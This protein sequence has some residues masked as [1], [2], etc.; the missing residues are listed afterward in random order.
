MEKLALFVSDD[1]FSKYAYEK[2][3]RK[4][5]V[6]PFSIKK[7]KSFNSFVVEDINLKLLFDFFREKSI[8]FV[9]FA[10]KVNQNI[11][12]E[13]LHPSARDFLSN[14]KDF[15]VENIMKKFVE[16]IESY[17]LKVLSLNE[18]FKDEI[19]EEKNYTYKLNE[20]EKEDLEFG[21]S[22]LKDITKHNIGQ[23]LIVK[24]GMVLG[25]EGIEGTDNLIKRIGRYCK[26][27][28]FIKGCSDDK[29][30]RFDLPTIG[31]K[32]IKNLKK[33]D[34]KLIGLK[35]GKTIILEKEKVINECK[36]YGIKIVGLK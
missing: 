13:N 12:F 30:M 24:N 32:T 36:K 22:V 26:G 11:V 1:F 21:F 25:V 33:F 27:F 10:G 31:M 5:S 19:V 29:D 14:I 18:I 28:V 4:Y 3:K 20:R 7:L 2:L 35:A 23:S 15:K 16:H 9:L 17:G 8:G 34:C 6:F